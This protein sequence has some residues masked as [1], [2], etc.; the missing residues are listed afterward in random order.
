MPRIKWNMRGF[1]QLR[2]DPG[3]AADIDRRARRIAAAAGDGYEASPYEGKSRHRASV[4]TATH[5]ARLD[6][7]RHNTL[8]GAMDAGR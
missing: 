7:A 5:K 6:N 3:V 8:L 2:R 1:E 4:I